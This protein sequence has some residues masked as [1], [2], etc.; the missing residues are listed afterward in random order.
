MGVKEMSGTIDL[1]ARPVY[2]MAQVD[3]I[4]R[5]PGGTARRWID[6][7]ARGGKTYPPLVRLDRTGDELVTWGEF[8]E[9]RLLS[10]FRESGVPIVRMRPAIVALREQ[11]DQ[12]YPLAHALPYLEE[13]GRELVLRIQEQVG[14]EKQ[15]QIVVVRNGQLA[16]TTQTDQ[17]IRSVDFADQLVVQRMHPLPDLDLVWLDPLRQFGEPVVRSVP[18]AVIAEQARAGDSQDLIE[19]LY[20]LNSQ[21]VWQA[22]RYEL[23]R[24]AAATA[25]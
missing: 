13:H 23:L 3:W 18:T 22:I 19:R 20:N 5:L 9:T 14:L 24:G 10:E 15:L 12:L 17:F 21:E 6:G 1:L 8:T 7:Y 2:G 11:F 16:L 4:L 25:A